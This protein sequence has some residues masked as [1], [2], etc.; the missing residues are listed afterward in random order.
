[1]SYYFFYAAGILIR[2]LPIK[3]VRKLA[4]LTGLFLFYILPVRK[5][6]AKSNLNLC[7]PEKDKNEINEILKNTYKN[8]V[9]VLFEILY[10]PAINKKNVDKFIKYHDHEVID[11]ALKKNSGVI[12]ASAHMSNWEYTAF[13]YPLNYPEKLYIVTKVQADEK[14]NNEI[15]NYRKMSGNS[16]IP[17]GASLK[18]IFTL[19][20]KNEMICF[21]TDQAGH[22]DY[23]V[24]TKFFNVNVPS[25]PGAA[26]IAL[27]LNS[28]IIFGYGIRNND[29]IYDVHFEKISKDD[30]SYSEDGIK[31]LTQRIQSRTEEIIRQHPE[32]WLWFH[33]RFKDAILTD[34]KLK[35]VIN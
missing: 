3:F 17:L 27:K 8:L 25:F 24:Y 2:A 28:E 29:G 9:I 19:L 34:A 31:V 4:K 1:M 14:V 13:A 20:K 23:S 30:L 11:D 12:F 6:V 5:S 16:L 15:N 32:Q 22:S 35:D 26:R 21:L 18:N 33:K 10:I 7:F